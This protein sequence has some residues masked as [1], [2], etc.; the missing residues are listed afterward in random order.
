MT[1]THDLTDYRSLALAGVFQ[2]A[3]LV[4]AQANGL[5]V[6]DSAREAVI[7]AITTHNA[8]VM[9]D[10]FPSKPVFKLGVDVAVASLGGENDRADVLRYTLQLIDLARRLKHS[11]AVLQRLGAG[12]DLVGATAGSAE[13]AALYQD[14]ISTLGK[15]IHVTGDPQ[16]L[17]QPA[18][19][20]DIRALLLAGVR[21][22]WLWLQLGGSRWQLLLSRRK[23]VDALRALGHVL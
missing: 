8:T 19:A 16:K 1:E 6:P 7:H 2:C 12:L 22:A 18:T 9:A 23:I 17:Q 5:H 20:D 15:R 3:E 14:T 11:P 13:L 4:R 10:V 21:F